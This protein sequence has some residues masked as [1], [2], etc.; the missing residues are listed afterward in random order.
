MSKEQRLAVDAMLRRQPKPPINQ[1]VEEMRTGFATMMASM[2]L[3]KD[4]R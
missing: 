1:S 3:P 2:A 4:V